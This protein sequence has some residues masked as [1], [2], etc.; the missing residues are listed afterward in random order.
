MNELLRSFKPQQT[1]QDLMGLRDFTALS[2]QAGGV[3]VATRGRLIQQVYES[4][5]NK[6]PGMKQTQQP[7]LDYTP[8]AIQAR[9]KE[10]ESALTRLYNRTYLAAPPQ[11]QGIERVED[12]LK[13]IKEGQDAET[14]AT[15]DVVKAIDNIPGWNLPPAQ[16]GVRIPRNPWTG[17]GGQ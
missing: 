6:Y 11:K 3:D 8:A 15:Q 7:S 16:Q 5:A 9:S 14:K 17:Q 4:L 2:V 12:V 10:F 13:R 1:L